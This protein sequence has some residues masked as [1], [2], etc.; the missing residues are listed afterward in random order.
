MP[1][2]SVLGPVLF[3]VFIDDIDVNI[4]STVLKFADDNKVVARVETE[5]REELRGD[6]VSLFG[7]S[8]DWQMLFNLD[9]CTVMHFGFNNIEEIMELGGKLLV[10]HTSER[11]LDVIVQSNLKVD[12]QSGPP[13]ENPGPWAERSRALSYRALLYRALS[14]LILTLLTVGPAGPLKV[15]GPLGICPPAPPS[16]RACMQCNKVACEANRGPSIKY[17][18]LHGGGGG[19]RKCDSL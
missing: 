9:K 15:T 4:C 3:V 18:T 1:Q 10:S 12:M 16:R 5:D 7:W 19:L 2:G 14:Y 11:D 8:Q 17:V 6:L 13:S